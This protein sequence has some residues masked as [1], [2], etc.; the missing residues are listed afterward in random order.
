MSVI[1]T[2]IGV[3][4]PNKI[5]LEDYFSSLESEP[6]KDQKLD[7]IEFT[8]IPK[9]KMRRMN[10]YTSLVMSSVERAIIDSEIDFQNIDKHRIG[11][12]YNTC[13]GPLET[14]L[15]FGKFVKDGDPDLGSPIVFANTV[16]NAAIGH[17]CIIM[18][19]KGVSTQ[20][21]GSNNL[22]YSE[23]LLK[24][25]HADYIFTGGIED[26][27]GFLDEEYQAFY[28][29]IFEEG[30]SGAGVSLLLQRD[31]SEYQKVYGEIGKTRQK[32]MGIMPFQ[33]KAKNETFDAL[34]DV[35]GQ[36]AQDKIDFHVS[37]TNKNELREMETMLVKDFYKEIPVIYP[38]DV[39]GELFGCNLSFGVAVAAMVLQKYPAKD[40]VLVTCYDT[41]G[42]YTGICIRRC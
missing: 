19:Y 22:L 30:I 32:Y 33:E 41:A 2:G 1:I 8:L 15:E 28:N 5:V 10:H 21:M 29:Q 37:M 34:N 26:Y 6:D 24:S 14:N 17:L 18:G 3:T 23:I 38:K 39:F 36:F 25:E 27:V 35:L 7:N 16:T 31:T 4:V 12:I 20:L 11:T 9:A 42:D 40:N 13:Y